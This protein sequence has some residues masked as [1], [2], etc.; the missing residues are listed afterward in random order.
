MLDTNI[1][2]DMVVSRNKS[3]KAESYYQLKELLDYG[4]I[5]LIVPRIVITEVFRHIDNE[6]DKLGKSISEIKKRTKDLYWIN[7]SEELERFNEILKPTKSSINLLEDEFKNNN[8]NYKRTY[9]ESFNKL[10]NHNNCIILEENKDIV[11][12]AEQRRIYKKRPFHYAGK[13]I[14]KDSM[15]DSIIIETLIN[16]NSLIKI[17]KEDKIYFISRNPVDFSEDGNNNVLHSDIL[18]DIEKS[19]MVDKIK[20]STLFTKTLLEEFKTEIESVGLT[21]QLEAEAEYERRLDIEESYELQDDYERES[22]GLSS[23]SMDYEEVIL[24]LDDVVNLMQ[25]IEEVREEIVE[26]CDEYNDKYDELQELVLQTNLQKLQNIIDNNPLIKIIIDDCNDEDNIKD[27]IR[28]LIRWRIGEE[29]YADFGEKFKYDDHFSIN[30]TILTFWDGMNN[31]YKLKTAGY[32]NPSSG[33]SDDID[34]YLF[35]GDEIIEEG[36]IN[37]C[38]GFVEYDEDGNVGDAAQEEQN[39]NIDGV[40][41]KLIDVKEGIISDLQW[42]IDKLQD[43]INLLTY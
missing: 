22:A 40:I 26:K 23:L 34:I 3:H 13:D 30:N 7:H 11:F 38:Y 35:K 24:Q 16:I 39:C 14:D 28:E 4:E 1:Y 18:S 33:D 19:G 27:G 42:R 10:Y 12:K 36:N 43:F 41:S 25:L 6:I 9:R 5:K 32:L 20:Y 17:N 37:I 21:E 8:K 31:E 2:I 15:A 29:F